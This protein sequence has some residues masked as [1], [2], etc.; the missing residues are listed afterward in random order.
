MQEPKNTI[1]ASEIDVG[2]GIDETAALR[3]KITKS[4]ITILLFALLSAPLGYFIRMLLSR[5]LSQEMFGL[6]YA[7]MAVFTILSNYN[8]LGFGYSVA[9]FI[10]KFK[11]HNKP[12]SIWNTFA[13]DL[14][15]EMG[16]S[17]LLS[18]A[19]FFST[20][21]LAELYFKEILAVPLLKIGIIF[22]ISHSIVSAFRKFYIGYEREN[23]YSAIDVLYY[24][25]VLAGTAYLYFSGVSSVN[26]YFL[27]WSLAYLLTAIIIFGKFF[28]DFRHI[29]ELPKWDGALFNKMLAYAIPSILNTTAGT[30]LS[31]INIFFLTYFAGLAAV[32]A[33]NIILP[34][35]GVPQIFLVPLWKSFIPLVSGLHEKSPSQ[36]AQV[37]EKMLKIG[38]LI[39]VYFC[40][41]I[42]LFPEPLIQ[43]LFGSKWMSIASVPLRIMAIGFIIY[44]INGFL[45]T[46]VSGL[47]LIKERLYIAIGAVILSIIAGT[48]LVSQFGLIGAVWSG[49]L[50]YLFSMLGNLFL[51]STMVSFKIPL[52]IYVKLIGLLVTV[53]L[54]VYILKPD[55]RGLP[56]ILVAG[57]VY[58]LIF[59]T[60]ILIQKELRNDVVYTV[61]LI[62]KKLKFKN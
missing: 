2:T 24:G 43:T 3:G 50:I 12:S 10:P 36:L 6:F 21:W 16:T 30:I 23:I 29:I 38:P 44:L 51:I 56:Q 27:F 14:I 32:G 62:T 13:Y 15:I 57:G 53:V 7:V 39:S 17:A 52:S 54:F 22:F 20:N 46:I 25:L 58:T 28:L 45:S 48:I 19:I 49:L 8:D 31:F 55:P 26:M 9:Y 4:S 35:V 41:F 34:I 40:L 37:T 18:I 11:K 5:S 33:Y 60:F 61:S 47:G 1:A 59:T 42:F